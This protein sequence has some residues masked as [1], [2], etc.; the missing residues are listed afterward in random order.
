MKIAPTIEGG[1]RMDPENKE[2]WHILRAIILD[3]NS[4]EYDLASRMGDLVTDE[5][6]AEDWQDIIVPDLR[7]SFSD[8]LHYIYASIEAAAA[9]EDNGETPIWITQEDAPKWYSAL[10]QARLSLEEK[11]KFGPDPESDPANL[12]PLRHEALLRNHFYSA[13]QCCILDHAMKLP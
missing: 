2:D 6:V 8:D 9:F 5:K 4:P 3:A 12:T 13:L 7:E 1:L 10:N 11:Y